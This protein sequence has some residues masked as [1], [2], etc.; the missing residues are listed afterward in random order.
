M[1][2]SSFMR[3]DMREW[4][5]ERV[6]LRGLTSTEPTNGRRSH[7]CLQLKD[8]RS[9]IYQGTIHKQQGLKKFQFMRTISS[10]R[11]H[12]MRRKGEG[13]KIPKILQTS[14]KDVVQYKSSYVGEFAL[15]I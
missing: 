13:Y 6:V 12:D 4:E 9:Q 14:F 10:K 2:E 3:G 11:L 7:L 8:V 15:Q 5:G 1:M